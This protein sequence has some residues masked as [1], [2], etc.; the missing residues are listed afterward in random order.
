MESYIDISAFKK[1]IEE[2]FKFDG[3]G[4]YGWSTLKYFLYEYEQHVQSKAGRGV[5]AKLSWSSFE[6]N[7]DT[8]EHIFPVEASKDCWKTNFGQFDNLEQKYY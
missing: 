3:N 4:Y 5:S 6:K 7:A 2:K 8:I 1:H